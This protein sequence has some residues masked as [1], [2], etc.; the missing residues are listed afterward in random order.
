[1]FVQSGETLV[2]WESSSSDAAAQLLQSSQ[3]KYG[4]LVGCWKGFTAGGLGKENSGVSEGEGY[5]R[6]KASLAESKPRLSPSNLEHSASR[7]EAS[8]WLSN[9]AVSRDSFSALQHS[10]KTVWVLKKDLWTF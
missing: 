10:G 6:V 1:M 2:S 5:S 8:S 3:L 7:D 4:S 9:R